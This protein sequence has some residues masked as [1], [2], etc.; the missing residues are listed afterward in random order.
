[1]KKSLPL[2]VAALIAVLL[3]WSLRPLKSKEWDIEFDPVLQSGKENYLDILADL[4][5]GDSRPNIVLILADDLGLTDISLYGSEYLSTPNI[6]SIGLSGITF[7]QAYSSAP[8]CSPSRAGM[9]TGRYQNRYGFDSQ[10]MTR[11]AKNNLEY[12]AFKYL[13]D[14]KP[15]YLIRNE[16]IPGNNQI[17]KQGMP[18]TEIMLSEALSAAGYRCDIVGKWHLGYGE[19]QHPNNRGFD[20][21]FGF[22]EAFSYFIDPDLPYVESWQF[23]EFS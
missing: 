20:S 16:S 12:M 23:D 8:I 5:V 6:D 2:A 19:L 11:Y 13:V 22:L 7:T 14:T 4:P 1:M 10:P 18:P 21:Y 17:E 15:M 3:I 9:L